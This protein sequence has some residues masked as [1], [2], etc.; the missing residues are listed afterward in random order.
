MLKRTKKT[1][2]LESLQSRYGYTFVAHWILGLLVFVIIPIFKSFQYAF[3]NVSITDDG[4]KT[5]FIGL[6]SFKEILFENPDYVDNMRDAIG[7]MFYS[8]PMVVALSLILAVLLN[9]RF[10]G[11]TVLRII[12]F[13]PVILSSSVI[14]KLLADPN[15]GQQVFNLTTDGEGIMD[16]QSILGNLDLPQQ[17]SDVLLFFLSNAVSLLWSCGVQT[18]LFLAGLQSI[19][20]SLYEVSTIEGANKWEEFWKITVPMLR[21]V[22]SLVIIYTMISLF[23]ASN[24]TIMSIAVQLISATD[25]SIASAMLWFYFVIVLSVIGIVL[26]FYNKFCLKKWE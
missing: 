11:R 15:L 1:H 8:L 14:V 17:I 20:S 21:H 13:L 4:F 16:Y 7:S 26:L 19:P 9:Q 5:K 22:I 10:P 24:N 23:T 3:S 6:A 2:S 18:I 12:F 25:Y